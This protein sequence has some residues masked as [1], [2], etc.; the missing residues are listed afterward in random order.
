MASIWSL[1][2]KLLGTKPNGFRLKMFL[3]KLA[4]SLR[5]ALPLLWILLY[6]Q[7]SL[8]FKIFYIYYK[9]LKN[10]LNSGPKMPELPEVETLAQDLRDAN[11]IG[12]RIDSVAVYW[13]A[14]CMMPVER[15][16]TRLSGQTITGIGR[17][18]K[19][20]ILSLS[21]GDHLLIH[22][23]MTG[24]LLLRLPE[25]KRSIHE[26]IVMTLD[27][28]QELRFHDTR[29]FGRWYLVSNQ[30]EMLQKLGPEPL[31]DTFTVDQFKQKLKKT[32]RQLKPLL[33]DQNFLAGLGNIYVDEA[34]WEGK[35]HPQCPANQ[36]SEKQ[37]AQLFQAIRKV[38]KRGL[39]S[40]GT[41][42]GKG[43]S[44]FYRLDGGQG[45][46]QEK[47]NVFRRT[48]QPCL[49]CGD[50]IIR[51]KV[52]QRSTHICPSCQQLQENSVVNH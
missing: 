7:S 5:F 6:L 32:A 9:K 43:K 46:H 44:N 17:R 26:H 1:Q 47:M 31:A 49:R 19:F 30:S 2:L 10:P 15:F 24:R 25:E 28:N 8:F 42:L 3:N 35:L 51:I 21:R 36:V 29:K 27:N 23:R 37:A 41:T 33:L 11:L 48:N 39:E 52:S 40:R 16:I 14:S 20:L 18:G 22:L 12:K 45:K 34:L 13:P 4:S 50:T 38:L